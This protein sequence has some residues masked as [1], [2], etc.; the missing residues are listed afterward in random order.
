MSNL[1]S[2][3]F[4]SFLLLFCCSKSAAD[5]RN[6]RPSSSSSLSLI[7]NN[8]Q[9]T[10]QNHKA[11]PDS[12]FK[13]ATGD[14][15]IFIGSTAIHYQWTRSAAPALPV[16][17]QESAQLL[18]EQKKSEY[19]MYRMDVVLLGANPNAEVVTELGQRYFENYHTATYNGTV[20]S[21]NKV[22]YKNIYKHID[23]VIY[24]D[25][26]QLKYDFVVHPGGNPR[27]IRLQYKG[28]TDM[29]MLEGAITAM[30]PF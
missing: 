27:D 26:N 28:A 8:G 24:T 11:R 20:S 10:D 3:F 19:N 22:T 1:Y 9:V 2:I 12:D 17:S 18:Q 30:T 21:F 5:H 14:I 4:T 6:T 7:E 29:K 23:W 16:K 25:H 13:L 15:S